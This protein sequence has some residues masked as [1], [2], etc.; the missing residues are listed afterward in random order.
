MISIQ[1]EQKISESYGGSIVV[2][3]KP[4]MGTSYIMVLPKDH[5]NANPRKSFNLLRK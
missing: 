1:E 4:G 5:P 3:S 2:N